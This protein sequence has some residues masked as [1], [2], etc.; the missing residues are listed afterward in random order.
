MGVFFIDLEAFLMDFQGTHV[1]TLGKVDR[2][3]CMCFAQSAETLVFIGFGDFGSNCS[4]VISR[5]EALATPKNRMV[6]NTILKRKHI[7]NVTKI[8]P[9][10]YPK[11]LQKGIRRNSK[12]HVFA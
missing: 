7:Q 1:F 3:A 6:L 10:T 9:K 8:D 12:K 11:G 2:L 5:N 4:K